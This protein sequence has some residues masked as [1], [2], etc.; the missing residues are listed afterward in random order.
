MPVTGL[1]ARALCRPAGKMARTQ[2]WAKNLLAGLAPR[3]PPDQP[4]AWVQA[5]ARRAQTTAMLASDYV[6]VPQSVRSLE[7]KTKM[8]EPLLTGGRPRSEV[9]SVQE[10]CCTTAAACRPAGQRRSVVMGAGPN[11]TMC[12]LC[13]T[14]DG[15]SAGHFLRCFSALRSSS[16]ENSLFS[17]VPHFLIGLFGS[18]GSTFLSSL[19]I[20]DI[21]PLPGFRVG[22]DPFPICWLT[23]CPFDSVLCLT[24]TL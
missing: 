17:S 21:S 1:P 5:N 20:L 2:A 9:A 3:W 14:A 22:E 23:F 4:R 15:P 10:R 12:R 11:W 19:Y 7:S 8:N 24:E 16:C 6:C 18:L 13:S